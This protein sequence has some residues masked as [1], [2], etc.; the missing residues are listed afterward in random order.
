MDHSILEVKR[1]VADTL[2]NIGNPRKGFASITFD[3]DG[4]VKIYDLRGGITT[5]RK[6]ENWAKREFG[7]LAYKLYFA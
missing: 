2:T 7:Y 3:Y 1:N 6:F 4:E 5:P